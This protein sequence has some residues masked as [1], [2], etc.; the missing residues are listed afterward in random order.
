MPELREALEAIEAELQRV[1]DKLAELPD[2]VRGIWTSSATKLDAIEA[3]QDQASETLDIV[4]GKVDASAASLNAIRM[5][6]DEVAE[7][8]DTTHTKIDKLVWAV[9][10]GGVGLGIGFVLMALVLMYRAGQEDAAQSASARTGRGRGSVGSTAGGA[11]RRHA[12]R[13]GDRSIAGAWE[14]AARKEGAERSFLW[15]DA[16]PL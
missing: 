11:E 9:L 12:I 1:T 7:S 8:Q 2:N 5:K 14:G 4:R 13:V 15:P 6:Q 16:W 3:K 10:G